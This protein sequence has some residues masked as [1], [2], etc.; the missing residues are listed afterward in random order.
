ML[1]TK[2]DILKKVCNQTVDNCLVTDILQ[3]IFFWWT[4]KVNYYFVI[5]RDPGW[6]HCSSPFLFCTAEDKTVW[7]IYYITG[8]RTCFSICDQC[9]DGYYY[10]VIIFGF[11]QCSSAKN[12]LPAQSENIKS[13]AQHIL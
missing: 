5:L 3:T 12:V 10:L 1:N 9:V 11:D 8:P 7:L 2:E 6:N 4:Y 13:P